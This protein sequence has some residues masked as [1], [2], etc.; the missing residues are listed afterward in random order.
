MP[1]DA[2]A[3]IHIC[4]RQ[5]L[6]WHDEAVVEARLLTEFRAKFD[7]WNATFTIPYHVFRQRLLAI[8]RQSL[9]AV[10]GVVC[11]PLDQ[12]PAGHLIVPVDDDDWF[13]PDL[14]HALRRA[15]RADAV[16]YLWQR[17][18]LEYRSPLARAVQTMARIAGRRDKF[19]CTT[20]NYAI[21]FD[22]SL[23][24]VAVSHR[25]ASEHFVRQAAAI[26]RIPATFGIQNRTLASQTTLA[27]GRP[28]ITHAELVALFQN[29][30]RLYHR[31]R[32]TPD[33]QWAAP[34]V[35]MMA[36]LM[37]ELDVR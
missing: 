1:P 33:L 2:A 37:T 28:T 30:R 8:A 24:P 27:Y 12:V 23:T 20:N 6:D 4:I 17:T 3:P 32:P 15:Y 16:G 26:R 25:C 35:G 9:Q 21:R 22:R 36:D 10:D 5:T 31:W 13:A 34:Y 18:A 11:S 7:A 29:H 19:I 14:G